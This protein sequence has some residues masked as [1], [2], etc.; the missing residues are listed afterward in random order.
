MYTYWMGRIFEKKGEIGK[1][2][3]CFAYLAG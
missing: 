1:A 2:L 3:S